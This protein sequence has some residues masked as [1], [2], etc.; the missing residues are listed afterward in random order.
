[1]KWHIEVRH[2]CPLAADGA[3]SLRRL[4][5]ISTELVLHTG[6]ETHPL[7]TRMRDEILT[8]FLVT[9]VVAIHGTFFHSFLLSPPNANL[10]SMELDRLP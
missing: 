9:L 3:N 1:M 2:L 6:T 8:I 4:S 10:L 7:P 5:A